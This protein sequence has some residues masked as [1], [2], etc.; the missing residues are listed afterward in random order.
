MDMRILRWLAE[1][2]LFVA[3]R[4]MV[5]GQCR[6]YVSRWSKVSAQDEFGVRV[7]WGVISEHNPVIPTKLP[8]VAD[9][10]HTAS[11]NGLGYLAIGHID[12]IA[13]GRADEHFQLNAVIPESLWGTSLYHFS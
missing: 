3:C 13:G 1:V 7:G 9:I 12:V 4:K 11:H 6:S 10:S 5:G 2:S 8:D